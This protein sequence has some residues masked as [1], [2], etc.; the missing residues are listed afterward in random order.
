MADFMGDL[1]E[2]SGLEEDQATRGV[3]A[4]LG[5]LKSRLD[6]EVFAKLKNAIPDSG[7]IVASFEEKMATAGAQA[8]GVMAA[9]KSA[10]GKILGSA[11]GT[12]GDILSH[13]NNAGLSADHL[14]SLLPHLHDML[15]SKLPP[16]VME[17][18]RE[19]IPNFGES[20]E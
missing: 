6:P 4:V 11:Q 14:K 18:I 16:D 1:T 17:K 19:H 3:G 12:G 15:E 7:D 9:V 10:A 5:M 8:G 20:A 2:K 13:F